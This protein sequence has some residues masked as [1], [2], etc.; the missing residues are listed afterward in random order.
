VYR[1]ST[2][3]S[4]PTTVGSPAL[5]GKLKSATQLHFY[6]WAVFALS[7]LLAVIAWFYVTETRNQLN[8]SRF[9]RET[10]RT[11]EMVTERL[12]KYEDALW[13]GVAMISTNGGDVSHEHWQ[14][15]ASSIHIENKYPGVMGIG[16][17]HSVPMDSLDDYLK[18]QKSTRPEFKIHPEHDHP[19]RLPISYITPAAP[20]QKAIGLDIA[21]EKNRYT[22]AIQAR[23]SGKSQVTGPITLVQDNAKTPGFLFYA[24]FYKSTIANSSNATVKD[25][26]ENFGGMVYAPFIASDLMKGALEKSKRHNNIRLSDGDKVLYDEHSDAFRDFDS[27]AMFKHVREIEMYGRTWKF[28]IWSSLSFRE[29]SETSESWLILSGGILIDV[30]LLSLFFAMSRSSRMALEHAETMRENQQLLV[31]RSQQLERS[32]NDLE[33]FASVASHDLQEPLRKVTICCE[34]LE[35]DFAADLNEEARSYIRNAVDGARRMQ[36]LIMKLLAYSRIGLEETGAMEVDTNYALETAL[37][38][39][40]SMIEETG[41]VVTS[42]HLP[43][44]NVVESRLTQLFQNLIGNSLK[45]RSD[46]EPKIHIGVDAKKSELIFS[47]SDNGIGIPPE[48]YQRVFGIFKRLH[49]R[50]QYSGTGIGLAICQRIVERWNGRIWIEPKEQPGCMLCFSVPILSDKTDEEPVFTKASKICS[51]RS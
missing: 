32:N 14:Q 22:A 44:V 30:L 6:H 2:K 36:S 17:I 12:S 21:H 40:D 42:D 11:I 51:L 1:K 10:N 5:S 3:T 39:L 18:E 16:V 19:V 9:D 50:S 26:R 37:L 46:A 43:N 41:A 47:V 20:N 23:D 49:T 28:D 4:L 34:L 38:N 45:Y 35:E 27:D 13:S 25:R 7:L 29:D 15:Y 31:K 8:R 33:Q 48:H 24:P